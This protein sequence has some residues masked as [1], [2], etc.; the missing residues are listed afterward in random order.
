MRQHRRELDPD[1]RATFSDDFCK[2]M[3]DTDYFK[4]ASHL[5]AY[6]PLW[7]ELDPRPLL[8][9]ALSQGKHIYLPVIANKQMWFA[10]WDGSDLQK[11]P[12]TQLIQPDRSAQRL[13]NDQLL[14]LVLL[15]L[16]SFDRK[17]RRLGQGGGY[18]DRYFSRHRQGLTQKPTLIGIAYDF[19]EF[20][21]IPHD[22]W[23]VPLSVIVTQREVIVPEPSEDLE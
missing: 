2:I 1:S 22:D 7:G 15:P 11:D 4:R 19:Q 13:A 3:A 23:D 16:V 12:A 8:T 17:G 21:C 18:Y 20:D 9:L 10:P 6:W 5:T 14:D